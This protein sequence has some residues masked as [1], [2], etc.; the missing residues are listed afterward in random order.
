L[1]FNFT[2]P[3]LS[4]HATEVGGTALFRNLLVMADA[5]VAT[6]AESIAKKV[7][8]VLVRE[9]LLGKDGEE[10]TNPDCDEIFRD[11]EGL[12]AASSASTCRQGVRW[13]SIPK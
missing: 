1:S 4:I 3:S 6:L 9:G 5:G 10:I 7:M 8:V 12:A 2:L 11:H 13:Q